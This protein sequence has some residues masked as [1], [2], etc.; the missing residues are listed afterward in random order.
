MNQVDRD[1][2]VQTIG[3]TKRYGSARGIEEVN[4]CL[5]PGDSYGFLGP[6]GAGKTTTIRCLLDLLQPSAGQSFLFGTQVSRRSAYLRDKVGCVSGEVGLIP[7]YTGEDHVRLVNGL[8]KEKAPFTEEL[9]KRFSLDLK[10]KVRTLSKG[11]KQ[12]LA[13]ILAFMHD[14]TLYILDEPTSG[15]DPFY[16]QLVFQLIQERRAQGATILLSSHILSEVELVCE[17]VGVISMGQL[18]MQES[19]SDLLA[20]QQRHMT[21]RF[22]QEVDASSWPEVPGLYSINWDSPQIMHATIQPSSFNALIQILSRYQINDL[23]IHQVSLE[24][25]FMSFYGNDQVAG[26]PILRQSSQVEG[27]SRG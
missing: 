2:I 14:N 7:G 13:L 22:A 6:N 21:I 10:A 18:F 20:R 24:E 8:R 1:A 23:E 26:E 27:G 19:L 15:L 9:A 17:R 3:L 25:A 12:K 5:Y 11:N 16:Q 4:L